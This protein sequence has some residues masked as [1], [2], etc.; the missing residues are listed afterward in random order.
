MTK[1]NTFTIDKI[2]LFFSILLGCFPILTFGMRS[3]LTIIWSV[4]GVYI[5]FKQKK[6]T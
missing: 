5:F 4:F 3:V 6:K 2:F 1:N